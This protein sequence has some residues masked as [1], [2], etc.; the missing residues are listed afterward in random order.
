MSAVYQWRRARV[1]KDNDSLSNK[2]KESLSPRDLYQIINILKLI[3]NYDFC[4]SILYFYLNNR[5]NTTVFL[6][7]LSLCDDIM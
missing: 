5:I 4:V 2:D 1:D 3:S 6:A 7:D